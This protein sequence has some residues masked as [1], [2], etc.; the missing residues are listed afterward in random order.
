MSVFT[1]IWW[2][3]LWVGLLVWHVRAMIKVHYTS[4]DS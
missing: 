2:F 1:K 4:N 3:A